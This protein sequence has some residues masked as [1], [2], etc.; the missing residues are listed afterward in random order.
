[1]NSL[2]GREKPREL[3]VAH[4]GPSPH[5]ADVKMDEIR[6]RIPTDAAVLQTHADFA[7]SFH[8][9]AGHG[10]IHRPAQ[11]MLRVFGDT[12]RAATQHRVGLRGAVSRNDHDRLGCSGGPVGLP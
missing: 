2:A 4:A 5:A 1:M 10:R 7:Y 6:T 3:I 9:H 12:M 11:Y 8:R